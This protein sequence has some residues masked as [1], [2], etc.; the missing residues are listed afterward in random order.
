MS[1]TITIAETYQRSEKAA[2]E[3][4]HHRHDVAR[5]FVAEDVTEEAH[6]APRQVLW[7]IVVARQRVHHHSRGCC[8]LLAL[9]PTVNRQERQ[10][11][12][13][14]RCELRRAEEEH[15][16]IHLDDIDPAES[17]FQLLLARLHNARDLRA[18]VPLPP[19]VPLPLLPHLH[20]RGCGP[21]RRADTAP[22]SVA[23]HSVET[24][25]PPGGWDAL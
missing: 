23:E 5:P 19:P 4:A 11:Q 24:F 25:H 7:H 22:S 13:Q 20:R 10:Y 15:M 12:L 9:L 18:R 8:G 14:Q 6:H 1:N 2:A 21:E 16:P 3:L 17:G